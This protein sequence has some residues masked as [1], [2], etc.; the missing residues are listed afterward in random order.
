MQSLQYG[1]SGTQTIA[2]W[3]EVTSSLASN[4]SA[5]FDMTLSS[6]YSKAETTVELTLL[7]T[8]T[9]VTPRLVFSLNKAQLPAYTG[10]YTITI[11][12]QLD[13][14]AIWGQIATFWTDYDKIWSSAVA[15]GGTTS[16]T[17][18]TDRAWISGSDVPTFSQYT[19]PDETGAYSIYQG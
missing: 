15:P 18:D 1:S 12:E 14:P 10:N 3:P 8:P 13:V 11:R 5:S 19:S 16:N 6:D 17:L 9:S 7:N 4:P 2:V